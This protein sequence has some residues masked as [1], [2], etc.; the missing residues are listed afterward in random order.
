MQVILKDGHFASSRC[1]N[2]QCI[3]FVG[4]FVIFLETIRKFVKQ[5]SK[6]NNREIRRVEEETLIPG[7]P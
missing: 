3:S 6:G 7:W 5:L 2:Q 4:G 1:P